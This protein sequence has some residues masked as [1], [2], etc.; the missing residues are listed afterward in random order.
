MDCLV[1]SSKQWLCR[2]TH[3]VRGLLQLYLQ[4]REFRS[5][6]NNLEGTKWATSKGQK[7]IPTSSSLSVG[8]LVFLGIGPRVLPMLTKE[9]LC[10]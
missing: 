7:I 10:R 3:L 4:D 8:W 6:K 1:N 9:E 5:M 2:P